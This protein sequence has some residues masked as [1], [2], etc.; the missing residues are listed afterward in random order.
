M[1]TNFYGGDER[2]KVNVTGT[3]SILVSW[4]LSQKSVRCHHDFTSQY[5]TPSSQLIPSPARD[6]DTLPGTSA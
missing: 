6:F 2:D 1:E 5:P 3:L 4:G